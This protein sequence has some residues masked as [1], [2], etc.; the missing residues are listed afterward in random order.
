MNQS[1]TL[2]TDLNRLQSSVHF[3]NDNVELTGGWRDLP[4]S[5]LF[6]SDPQFPTSFLPPKRRSDLLFFRLFPK[7]FM[8]GVWSSKEL[9][10]GGIYFATDTF[11]LAFQPKLKIWG[12]TIKENHIL[13]DAE[14]ERKNYQ[15]Y[16][17]F[18]SWSTDEEKRARSFVIEA[19]RRPYWDRFRYREELT[20]KPSVLDSKFLENSSNNQNVPN[21]EKLQFEEVAE[22]QRQYR[23]G[24]ILVDSR[25]N[26]LH[27]MLAGI[28]HGDVGFRLSRLRRNVLQLDLGWYFLPEIS[29][30]QT[31]IYREDVIFREM[32]LGLGLA[33]RNRRGSFESIVR[34]SDNESIS[35]ELNGSFRSNKEDVF[36]SSL[37]IQPTFVFTYA[38]QIDH[39]EYI[40]L[41][42]SSD[43]QSRFIE[44]AKFAFGLRVYSENLRVV[45]F[46]YGKESD[47]S[48][49][50][51]W[52][53][54]RLEFQQ[55]F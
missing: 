54:L 26:S 5:T 17:R 6:Y 40:G 38:N 53:Y 35:I 25:F 36:F 9:A 19:E 45:F 27:F 42:E 28:D 11:F 50:K 16:A 29:Y 7:W 1:I 20:E 21:K 18:R 24:L 10:G 3:K 32:R 46:Y 49:I 23:S 15:G 2:E 39:F 4:S 51:D 34:F 12:F 47:T 14:G 44:R 43:G 41:I 31:Q 37:W 52:G 22:R 55:K 8:P 30:Y 48:N 13:I 33:N